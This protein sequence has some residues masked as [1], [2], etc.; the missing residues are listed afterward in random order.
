[1]TLFDII[2]NSCN[3]VSMT[4]G[5]GYTENIYHEALCTQ[6]RNFGVS[7][8]KEVVLPVYFDK[9][10]VGNVRADIVI[11][12]HQ[13]VI[14]CKAIDNELRDVNLPQIRTYMLALNYN[15]G[16][17]VNFI[18]NPSKPGVQVYFVTKHDNG[19]TFQDTSNNNCTHLDLLGHTVKHNFNIDE[20]FQQHILQ[21][22]DALLSKAQC[23]SIFPN[24]SQSDLKHLIEFIEQKC[25]QKF[26]DF[27]CNGIKHTAV[28]K[29]WKII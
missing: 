16:F 8:S 13:I 25:N 28:I 27:Q 17:F 5:K 11:P 24:K 6:L 20:W 26:K 23:K 10:F 4:L 2:V 9:F 15:T 3:N 12:D 7:C 29:G 1:M 18:Q 19:F 22:N 21:E 14:E